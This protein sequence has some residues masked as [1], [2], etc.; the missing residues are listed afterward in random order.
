MKKMYIIK[1][2]FI[3]FDYKYNEPITNKICDMLSKCTIIIFSDYRKYNE[4][5]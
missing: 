5:I 4:K 3:V 1:E 2:D